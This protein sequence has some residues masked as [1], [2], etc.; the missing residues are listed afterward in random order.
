MKIKELDV[1]IV[2]TPNKELGGRYFTFI[3]LTASN[4]IIGYGEVYTDSFGPKAIKAM[5]KDVFER[6]VYDHNPFDHEKL[7]RKIYSQGF[8]QRPDVSLSGVL[9]A[10]DM[11]CFDIVGKALEQPVYNLIGGKMHERL[12]AYTYIYGKPEDSDPFEVYINPDLAAKRALEY[13]EEGFTAVK[14]DPAGPYTIFGGHQPRLSDLDLS[15]QF[16]KNIRDAVGNKADILFGTHGQFSTSGA[17]RMM[18][19]IAP[20]DPL[21]FEEPVPPDNIEDMAKIAARSPIPIATG[22]RLTTKAEFSRVLHHGAASILQM[23]LGRVGGIWEG[24]KI[25][26]MAEAYN[27]Q[28]APHLYCGPFVGLANI[29]LATSC[30]N[31]LI[32]ESILQWQGFYSELISTPPKFDGGYIIPPTSPGLGAEL[33]EDIAR[34]NPYE[35]ELLHLN[36]QNEPII[37]V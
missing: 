34:N 19:A 24:K 21:W 18:N 16:C 30:P 11:A 5:L 8:T 33:N 29:H 36:M 6:Q 32:L 17:I 14:F 15:I 7:F 13:V 10:F 12:R 28:I 9:S 25:A 1:F 22:E 26:G 20:F 35:G 2:A 4:G 27:A 37:G 23:N 3:K 31:F